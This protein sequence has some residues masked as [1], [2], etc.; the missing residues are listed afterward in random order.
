MLDNNE[1]NIFLLLR[2]THSR[3]ISQSFGKAESATCA[4]FGTVTFLRLVFLKQPSPM[5]SRPL[6]NVTE[7]K[8]TQSI[9]VLSSNFFTLFGITIFVIYVFLKHKL[10]ILVTVFGM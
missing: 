10:P 2:N 8:C 5:L 4:S 6:G 7:I 9:N 3:R 1:L